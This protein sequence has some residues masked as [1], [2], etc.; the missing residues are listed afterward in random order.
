MW[1]GSYFWGWAVC[2][3]F[4]YREDYLSY[5]VGQLTTTVR[6]MRNDLY[7]VTGVLHHEYE[8]PGYRHWSTRLTSMLLF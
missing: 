1:I 5:A 4:A 6:D 8:Q 3:Y 2:D 7:A